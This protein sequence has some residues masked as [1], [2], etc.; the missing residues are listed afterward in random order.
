MGDVLTK[1]RA[2]TNKRVAKLNK[3]T[4]LEK[5]RKEELECRRE[6]TEL[7]RPSIWEWIK[8]LFR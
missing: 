8:K 2:E 6:L 5:L 1:E 7:S 3:Q 4:K